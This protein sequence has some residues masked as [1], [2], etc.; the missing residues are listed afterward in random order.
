MSI[1]PDRVVSLGTGALQNLRSFVGRGAK[2]SAPL[3]AVCGVIADLASTIGKFAL[4]LFIIS[5]L[6]AVISGLLWFLHYRRQFLAAAADGKLDAAELAQLRERN[7]WSVLFAFS[8]VA[9]VVMG[10]FVVAERVSGGGD[11]GVIATV[12]PGM[13]KVQQSLFRVEKKLDAVQSDTAAIRSDTAKISASIEEIAKRF[14]N[15][16]S[17][18]GIIPNAK[19]P[20]EH[21]HNARVHELGGNFAAA[22]KEYSEYLV[23][24][25]D[26][27]DPWQSYAAM[28][29]A[30]EGRAGAI[31]TMRYFGD[32]L[33]PRTVS[34]ETALASLEEG[35]A[36]LTKLQALAAGHP[37]YGPL[38]WLLAQEYSE[39]RRGEQ[40]LADQR[41]EKDWLAK[42]RKTQGDG[43]F[44]KYFLDK[45]EA[46]KWIESA[47]ARWAKLS[48]TPENVLENPV[49]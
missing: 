14:D 44:D 34:Y 43:Y 24:N 41:S 48:S 35:D 30:Q 32:K 26:F 10:G 23:A 16:S 8:I 18:G 4:Y 15:L 9:S 49:T 45:R 36:R 17:T 46:S 2:I 40:T 21:Y 1:S 7:V 29:K 42:F 47:E 33:T 37:D 19:T 12:V 13:D 27:I 11:K 6:T 25:L 39:A 3:A 31:E 28:L 22:R 38:P 20:E 5:A